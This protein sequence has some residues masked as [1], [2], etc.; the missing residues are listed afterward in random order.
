LQHFTG[1]L[2][3]GTPVDFIMRVTDCLRWSSDHWLIAQE[4][5][6]V[7]VEPAAFTAMIKVKP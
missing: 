1:K 3:D 6:S 5:I 4:H 2:K 7:P